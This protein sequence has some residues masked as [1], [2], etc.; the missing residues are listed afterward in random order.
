MVES[1]KAFIRQVAADHGIMTLS[2]DELER[3]HET[4]MDLCEGDE[5]AYYYKLKDYFNN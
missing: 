3:A 5:E 1:L 4:T 2:E